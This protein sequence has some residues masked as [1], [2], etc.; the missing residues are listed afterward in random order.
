MVPRQTV[1]QKATQDRIN[2]TSELLGSIKAVKML[3]F[4]DRFRDLIAQ[5]RDEEIEVG[6]KFREV[7]VYAN[8]IGELTQVKAGQT[9]IQT[10]SSLS[11][12]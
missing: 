10:N 7:T 2:F 4:A 1:Y 12:L 5:K 3:G 11:E 9:V 8:A 6:K